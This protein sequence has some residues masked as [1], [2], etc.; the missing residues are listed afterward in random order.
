MNDVYNED[1]ICKGE[2]INTSGNEII[3]DI[4]IFPNPTNEN[5]F[6]I[7]TGI[8]GDMVIS[9]LNSVGERISIH[10]S[11]VENGYE[12]HTSGL[13]SGVYFVKVQKDQTQ[14]TYRMV[15]Y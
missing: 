14:N 6:V 9:L 11:K 7:H 15:K 5:I 3:D 8:E 12:L 1:C 13:P 10:N 2:L 4:K